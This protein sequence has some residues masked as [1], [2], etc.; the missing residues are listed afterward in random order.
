[1]TNYFVNISIRYWHEICEA[2][3]VSIKATQHSLALPFGKLEYNLNSFVSIFVSDRMLS[4][5]N[6]YTPLIIAKKKRLPFYQ[7]Q[8]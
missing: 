8:K 6:I 5:Q 7:A 4:M 1:M 3:T 2:S